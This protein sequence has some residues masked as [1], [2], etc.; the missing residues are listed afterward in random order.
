LPELVVPDNLRS[1]ITKAHRYEPDLNP[2]YLDMAMHYGVAIVPTRVRKP[3]DKAKAE[4]SVQIIE[5]WI[6]AA[7]RNHTFF[8]LTELNQTLQ[9]LVVKINQRAFKKLPGSRSE[10]FQSLEQPLLTPI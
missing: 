1:G 2:T 3:K 9:Q 8:S 4:V 5:R 7:L 10:L 6:L